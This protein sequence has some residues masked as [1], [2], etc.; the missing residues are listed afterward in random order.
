MSLNWSPEI[1]G[2][3]HGVYSAQMRMVPE[4]PEV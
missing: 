1:R 3:G 4:V 2:A